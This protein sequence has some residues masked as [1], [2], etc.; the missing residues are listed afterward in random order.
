VVP[1]GF[2]NKRATPFRTTY[3]TSA[4]KGEALRLL[5]Y[6]IKDVV[7]LWRNLKHHKQHLRQVLGRLRDNGVKCQLSKVS[8]GFPYVDYL[9]HKVVPSGTAL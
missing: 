4:R 3:G 8:L 6:W 2:T 5:L 1:F 9:G 7:I